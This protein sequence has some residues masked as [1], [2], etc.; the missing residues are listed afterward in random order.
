MNT[1]RITAHTRQLGIA[2]LLLAGAT[3]IF[4]SSNPVS[5][6]MINPARIDFIHIDPARA[7]PAQERAMARLRALN[8]DDAQHMTCL[9]RRPSPGAQWPR[10]RSGRSHA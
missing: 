2:T 8:E 9:R 6:A 5:A 4:A 1:R 7:T 10:P 3:G